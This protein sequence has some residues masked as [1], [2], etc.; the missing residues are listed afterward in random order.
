MASVVKIQLQ[1][2]KSHATTKKSYGTL[3]R[4]LY[5]FNPLPCLIQ[6]KNLGIS[7][8]YS[9]I[10]VQGADK[11]EYLKAKKPINSRPM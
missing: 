1:H 11:A 10:V 9:P 5:I 4:Y 2:D 6:L 8:V 7:I 3:K